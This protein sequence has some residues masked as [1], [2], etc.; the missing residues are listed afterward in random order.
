MNDI[1]RYQVIEDASHPPENGWVIVGAT[2]LYL[3]DGYIK[4]TQGLMGNCK[5]E[6][7]WCAKQFTRR[8]LYDDVHQYFHAQTSIKKGYL[9]P[10]DPDVVHDYDDDGNE[11]N[12]D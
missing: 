9:A 2:L 6:L 12:D 4:R 8:I 3:K 5:E 10:Y 7:I 1:N 11:D